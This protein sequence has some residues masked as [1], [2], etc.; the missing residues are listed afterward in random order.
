MM[1]SMDSNVGRILDT[2]EKEGLADNTIVIFTSDN[3]AERYSDTWPFSGMKGELLEGG[4]RVP[5]IVRWPG[6][7]ASGSTSEQVMISMDFIPTLLAA[8]QAD[9]NDAQFDGQ[10][11][12]PVLTGKQAPVE[13]TLFWRY[14]SHDQHAVHDGDWKY[15]KIGDYEHLYNVAKDPRERAE[16]ADKYP[17]KFAELKAKFAT[18][19]ENMLP[20]PEKS[21]SQD[22]IGKH[23]DRY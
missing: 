18:W 3:G 17:E 20:Y 19:N 11:L 8:A 4:I 1:K 2:L 13:R 22:N 21:F 6:N 16:L 5:I 23:G 12:L 7:V 14:K 10:N 15:L 9:V